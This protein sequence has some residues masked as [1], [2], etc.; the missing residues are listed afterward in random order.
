MRLQNAVAETLG[1]K[2]LSDASVDSDGAF[3][4]YIPH[5][6]PNSSP[7]M[8]QTIGFTDN[9]LEILDNVKVSVTLHVMGICGLC[10]SQEFAPVFKNFTFE[11]RPKLLLWSQVCRL[12][13]FV[14][15]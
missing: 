1:A 7:A 11:A 14:E 15:K 4:I 9:I 3:C 2:N 6:E 10:F 13:P 5:S 8:R 12:K